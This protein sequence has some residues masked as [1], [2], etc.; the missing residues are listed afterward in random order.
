MSLS[1]VCACYSFHQDVK[2][3]N[4]AGGPAVKIPPFQYLRC[5]RSLA[6]ES[7]PACCTWCS[8]KR[9]A[10]S[11][12]SFLDSGLALGLA[13]TNRMRQ[14]RHSSPDFEDM[15]KVKLTYSE[16]GSHHTV[17]KCMVF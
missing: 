4:Y 2:S 3:R 8:Q 12:S 14:K 13:P 9:D 10:E 11:S 1:I 6:G 17:K 5:S 15:Q 16:E 7:D